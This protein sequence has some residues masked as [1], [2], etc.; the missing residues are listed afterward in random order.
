[1]SRLRATAARDATRAERLRTGLAI[2]PRLAAAVVL[3]I[4]ASVAVFAAAA[5]AG[6][7]ARAQAAAK[8]PSKA[9]RIVVSLERARR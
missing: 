6:G 9:L 5:L 1:M 4:A 3:C 7:D 2:A 8:F